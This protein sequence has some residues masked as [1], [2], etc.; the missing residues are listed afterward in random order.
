MVHNAAKTIILYI[1]NCARLRIR[2]RIIIIIIMTHYIDKKFRLYI[3]YCCSSSRSRNIGTIR[4]L[5][6]ILFVLQNGSQNTTEIIAFFFLY[7]RCVHDYF[8]SRCDPPPPTPP[9]RFGTQI[10]ISSVRGAY[11]RTIFQNNCV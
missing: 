10:E 1:I 9:D 7:T 8:L 6:S 2:R 5:F 3:S 11:F 4:Y